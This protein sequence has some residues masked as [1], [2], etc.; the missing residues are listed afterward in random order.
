M[1]F[2]WYPKWKQ[3]SKKEYMSYGFKECV[4]HKEGSLEYDIEKMLYEVLNNVEERPFYGPEPQGIKEQVLRET[5]IREGKIKPI[6]HKY[7]K[8]IGSQGVALICNREA[9]L[10]KELGLKMDKEE[11]FLTLH[12]AYADEC[13]NKRKV[14]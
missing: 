6:G 4:T 5:D 1:I 8:R 13:R 14:K 7:Y 3:I 10:I 11:D 9:E 12:N 2:E